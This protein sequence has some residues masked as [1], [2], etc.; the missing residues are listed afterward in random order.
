MFLLQWGASSDAAVAPTTIIYAQSHLSRERMRL[1]E[2]HR[3]RLQIEKDQTHTGRTAK[4]QIHGGLCCICTARVPI[5]AS[6]VLDDG[7]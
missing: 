2:T 1:A 3:I 4:Q 6:F 7:K 5:R